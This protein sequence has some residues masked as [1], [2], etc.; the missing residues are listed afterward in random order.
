MNSRHTAARLFLLFSFGLFLVRPA[1]AGETAGP[2]RPSE[3]DVAARVD[4]AL[5][6]A[7][8]DTPLP[9]VDDE[10]FLR[11][12]SLDLTGKLPSPDD[13]HRF[14]ADSDPCKRARVIDDLLAGEG[15][16][17]NWGRYWRDVLTYHTPASGNYLRWESF[18][19]WLVEQ[20]RRNRPWGETVTALVT[21]T[22]VNDEC[23]PVNYLTAH[24]GNPVELAATTS[25]VFLGVQLQCAQ[26]HDAKTEPWKREQFHEFVAFFGRA[27]LVQHKDVSGRGTP[28]AIEGREDGQYAMVDKKDPSHLI[29][30][31]PRFLPGMLPDGTAVGVAGDAP[32]A[33]RRA[34]L[35]RFLTSPQNPWFARAHVN[36]I[37]TS[38]MGWGFYPGLADLGGHVRPRYPE[39]LDLLAGEWA[40]TNYDMRWLFR[41][42]AS[43]QAYQRQL[44]PRP[45]GDE[46]VPAAVCPHRLRPEQIFEALVKALGFDENDKTIPA[47][48]PSSAPAVARHTGLRHMVCQAFKIDPSLPANEVQGTIPQALL[49]MNSALVTTYTAAK[50]KT[51]LAEALAKG[52][53]DDDIV[54]ALYEKTLARKP[55]AEEMAICRRYL[56]RVG[57]RAEALEDVF[58]SLLNSTEFLT[59][60]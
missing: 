17:V 53:A 1:A 30:M 7:V 55:K 51:F 60:N 46:P 56:K 24:Y 4:A 50:G 2:S 15:H 33:E 23:P 29:T 41:T 5:Q 52:M 35:A 12:V 32:D 58:W 13:L 3:R 37:W 48:A 59:N 21:A 8:G 42:I 34:A 54:T 28:Y 22:G 27:R 49:M 31:M 19:R 39:T 38:L 44:Q 25:R 16:A 57:D 9:A 43:T 36:R 45:T 14:T 20:V 10:A 40:R 6:R 47:P 18:D 11:R 26:C